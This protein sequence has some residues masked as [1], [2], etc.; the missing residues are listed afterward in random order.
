MSLNIDATYTLLSRSL[1]ALKKII[2]ERY[3]FFILLSLFF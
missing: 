2:R 3:P 1:Q